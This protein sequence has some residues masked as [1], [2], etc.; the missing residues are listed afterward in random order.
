MILYEVHAYRTKAFDRSTEAVIRLRS[1]HGRDV[2]DSWIADYL[3]KYPD[4]KVVVSTVGKK[5][6][7]QRNHLTKKLFVQTNQGKEFV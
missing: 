1:G 4:G 7:R 2:L 6:W 3:A 5:T